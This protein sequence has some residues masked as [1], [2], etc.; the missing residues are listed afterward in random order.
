MKV[1]PGL[2]HPAGRPWQPVGV[3][4]LLETLPGAL[5]R[6]A[7]EAW[8]HARQKVGTPPFRPTRPPAIPRA[9][10]LPLIGNALPLATDMG[11][12]L[13]AQYRAL[14]PVFRVGT[15]QY[16]WVVLAGPEATLFAHRAGRRYFRSR[17]FWQDFDTELGAARS[18]T[19]MDGA[20]HARMRK[21]QRESFSRA[22]VENRL[23]ELVAVTRHE[24]GDWLEREPRPGHRAI[25]RLVAEQLGILTTGFS[26]R[27]YRDDLI[28]FLEAA[29]G[30]RVTHHRPGFTTH[31]PRVRRARLRLEALY[32]EVLAAHRPEARAGREPDLIDHLLELHGTDSQFLPETDMLIAVLG[33]Y[34]AGLE[35]AASAVS[36]ML[37]AL[38]RR[39][40]LLARVTE[41]ADAFF[42]AGAGLEALPS[43][44][45]TRRAFMETLRM[46]PIA[47]ALSR[48]VATSFRFGGY[49]IKARERV[50]V[51]TA[52]TL[53][54]PEHFPDPDRF[55]ID[56]Y[57]PGREE[58]RTPGVYT[59]FGI[60]E[61]YCLGHGFAE[62]L[63]T[64]TV[65]TL[66]RDLRLGLSGPDRPLKIDTTPTPRPAPRA[67]FLLL[68][69][70]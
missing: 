67:R 48:T 63:A 31:V 70:R 41:E 12:F 57:L 65:A 40:A 50:L 11:G 39:P 60:G 43:L 25:Q 62:V 45:A 13:T 20:E 51:A 9:P 53:R 35:T 33:P 10:G 58:H 30:A 6:R 46:H 8:E 18:M 44:D 4:K 54:L 42:A 34:F 3:G 15:L 1:F 68:G 37:H 32:G 26:P 47:P 24:I 5:P 66:L 56:R 23:P 16:S 38:L 55:D 49:H 21:A 14:G 29:L 7:A 22:A 64:V 69:R 36:F 59:P 17:E 2:F 52:A 19:S 28:D 27:A 61:H